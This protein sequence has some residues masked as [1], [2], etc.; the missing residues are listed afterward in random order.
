LS[1]DLAHGLTDEEAASRLAQYAP[2]RLV[3][4]IGRSAL[5]IFAA[6]FKSLIVV[7][8]PLAAGVAFSLSS[9]S[10]PHGGRSKLLRRF[11]NGS[12][13]WRKSSATMKNMKFR[14]LN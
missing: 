1:S 13:R 4:S 2:N 10:S 3:I 6:Q 9:V 7:L 5:E 14:L 11:R 8:L 12:E